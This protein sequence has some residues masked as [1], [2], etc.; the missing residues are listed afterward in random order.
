[1]ADEMDLPGIVFDPETE[2]LLESYDWPGNVREL[3]NVL[4]RTLSRMEGQIVRVEDLPFFISGKHQRKTF[5]VR[6]TMKKLQEKTEKDTI[7]NCLKECGY[8]KVQAAKML[9]IHRTLL[10]RKI[11]KHGILLQNNGL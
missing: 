11:K 1:M 6:T 3:S 4:E 5:D 10:Y 2:K 8:N 9:G 7:L